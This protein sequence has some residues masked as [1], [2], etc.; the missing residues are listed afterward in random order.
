[1]STAAFLALDLFQ[2]LLFNWPLWLALIVAQVAMLFMGDMAY[3]WL[4][5][6]LGVL[7]LAWC[8]LWPVWRTFGHGSL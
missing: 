3:R 2:S 4:P 8:L 5:A 1:M 6:G 7:G